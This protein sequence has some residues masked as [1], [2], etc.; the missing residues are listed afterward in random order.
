MALVYKELVP[1]LKHLSEQYDY[2]VI[3]VDDGSPDGTWDEIVR[4]CADDSNVKGIHLS[5]NFGK[6]IALTAGIEYAR[7]DA[8]ITLDGD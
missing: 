6:E 1:V 3:F 2:E 5:R 7:G 4:I 8:V